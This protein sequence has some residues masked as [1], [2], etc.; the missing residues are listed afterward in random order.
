MTTAEL[1]TIPCLSRKDIEQ[2][3]SDVLREYDLDI[4]PVDLLA[5]GRRLDMPIDNARFRDKRLVGAIA[6]KGD[7]VA[8]LVKQSSPPFQKLFTI[9]HELGHYVL[10]LLEDGEFIDKEVDLFRRPLDDSQEITPDH[11]REIEAN[12][13][14]TAILMPEEAIKA[15]W[16]WLRRIAPMARRFNVSEVAMATRVGQLGLD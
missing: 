3:A 12:V 10:H 6:K 2:R 5:L 1:E 11:R 8:I 15:E 14:A 13:F 9:A 7:Q 4:I 16:R